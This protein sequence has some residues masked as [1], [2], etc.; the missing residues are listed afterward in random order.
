MF[1]VATRMVG[2]REDVSDILQ[3]I[4]I[5][6]FNKINT[7]IIIQYPKSWLYRATINK[8]LDNLR[9]RKRFQCLDTICEYANDEGSTENQD[10]IYAV[11][12][13]ISRLRS[14]EKILITLYSE[15]LAYKEISEVTGIK[16]T[17]VGKMLSRTLKKI[18]KELKY[19][20]YDMS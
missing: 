2:D 1:R 6:L 20:K 18:E 16:F 11:N 19:K 3:E 13:A 17:S 7:G 14:R 5:D 9:Y 8:C 4:F 10:I 12:F 15:G